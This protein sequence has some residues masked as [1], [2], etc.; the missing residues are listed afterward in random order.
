MTAP[1]PD[2]L[3]I[4]NADDYG[5]TPGVCEGIL[6]AH[7]EGVVTSTSA[8][9]VAP[10]FAAHSSR[11]ADSGIGVGAHLCLVGEDPLLLGPREIPTLVDARGR[12]AASW[13]HLAA[14]V[15]AGRVDL[16]DVRRELAAQLDALVAAGVRPTHVDSHQHVHHFP[17]LSGVV[18]ALAAA[19][20][21]PAA[22]VVR[23]TRRGPVAV[24]V[25]LLARR[26][27]R[28]C[29]ELGVVT[30]VASAGLDGA[31]HLD[32]AAWGATLDRLAASGADTAEVGCHPGVADDPDRA[33]YGWGYSW[34]DELA[35]LCDPSA[36]R[37][38]DEAG[39]VLGDYRDLVARRSPDV[40]V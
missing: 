34:S 32:A 8:L 1:A 39:F 21:V 30:P 20:G 37:A 19:R 7:D 4:V 27:A 35:A 14:R 31:G 17:R 15:A 13:R 3:L 33:R 36:R 24:A 5:L 22:R 40:A 11:L 12:P 2:R 25:R 10:A 26:F 6:R 18:A 16:D 38:V 29:E 23:S 28:T 9:V